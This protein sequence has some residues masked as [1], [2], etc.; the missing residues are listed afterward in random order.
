[1]VTV[2]SSF[3]HGADDETADSAEHLGGHLA[4]AR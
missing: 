3:I 1:M 2:G 4:R